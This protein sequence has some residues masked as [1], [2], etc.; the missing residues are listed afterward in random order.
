M[1]PHNPTYAAHVSLSDIEDEA[2]ALA[3]FAAYEYTRIEE[4]EAESSLR[5]TPSTRSNNVRG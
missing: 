3:I 4:E 2:D 1:D 5:L